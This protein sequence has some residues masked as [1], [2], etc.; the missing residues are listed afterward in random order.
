MSIGDFPE[1]LSQTILVGIMLVGRLGV[2]ARR[3]SRRKGRSLQTTRTWMVSSFR[4]SAGG[5]YMYNM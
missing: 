4:A 1:S 3:S 2:R 5:V